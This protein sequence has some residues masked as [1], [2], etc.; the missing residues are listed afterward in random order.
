MTP[1]APF[2]VIVVLL[3]LATVSTASRTQSRSFD[4]LTA[5]VQDIQD[6]V[7]AGVLTYERLVQLYLA[8]IAAY[9]KTGPRLNAV[10][11]VN[12]RALDIARERD[13]E[14]RRSGL[15]SPLHG[16]PIAI[17]DNVDTKDLPTTGGN[18]ALAGTVPARD[19]FVIERLRAAGA[20]LFLKTNMDEF[21]M[22]S[23]GLSTL[24]GQTL[25]AFDVRR[26]PGGSSGGTAVAVAA[27]FATVGIA[28]ETG[29]SIRGPASNA[30]LVGLAPTRGLISRGGVIPLSFTQDRVGIHARTAADA[31]VLLSHL[32]GFDIEDLQTYASLEGRP[33][34]G[35]STDESKDVGRLRV[36]VLRQ[37]FPADAAS[38]P[39]NALVEAA[40][41]RLRTSTTVV[42]GLT[43]RLDLQPL[44]PSLRVNNYE[45]RFAF[46]A[47]LQRRGPTSPVRSLA[48]L[49]T[50][51]NYLKDLDSRYDVAM[52]IASLDSDAEYLTRLARQRDV[53]AALLDVMDRARLDVLAYPLKSL[54]APPLG[55][56][57]VGG[58]R[59][60]PFSAVAGLPA[61]VVSV[62]LHPD[63]LPIAIEFLGRPFTDGTLL[64]LAAAYERLRGL[65]PLPTTVPR[66]P[67][68]V[69]SYEQK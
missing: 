25:N 61:V 5:S 67:D 33:G 47:Y 22:G 55:E 39:G 29:M 53:R 42:D 26:S 64:A 56:A 36:G 62:G 20:I 16:I 27:G 66:L 7:A 45:V 65:Q 58:P 21:A 17:K 6:A 3:A 11:H 57:E 60:N 41:G 52:K 44:I 8:R 12:P 38:A 32:R 54:P 13:A 4:L 10:L 9:D 23:Q 59:D 49:I 48:A 43:T 31:A 19:A 34:A 15:R 18:I 63:G 69:F 51:G 14:R 1:T 24:G 40:L 37:L 46:D 30:G 50:S 68:E 2:V 35:A 28:T